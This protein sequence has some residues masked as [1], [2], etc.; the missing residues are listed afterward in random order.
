MPSSVLVRSTASAVAFVATL[1]L[2]S[3]QVNVALC[4]AAG[5]AT[6]CQWLTTQAALQATGLFN[7]VDIIDVTTAG[8]GTPTLAQLSQYD[9]LLC[10]T[11]TTPANNVTWGDVLADY[12]DQGGGV[13]VAVFANSSTTTGRNIGGRW[14]TGYEVV[15]DQGGSATG[16]ASL[17]IVHDPLHPVMAGVGAFTGGTISSRPTATAL[18]IG[19]TLIAEWSDGKVLVAQG[20]LSNRV[21][22]GFY[23]PPA[24]CSQSGWAQGGDQLMA[25]AL[26]H[27]ANTA[28]YHTYGDGC[29]GTAGVPVLAPV[30][31]SRPVLGASV[32]VTVTNAPFDAGIMLLGFSDTLSGGIPL[33]FDL[34]FLGMTGCSLLTDAFQTDFLIGAGGVLGYSLAIPNAPVFLGAEFYNQAGIFDPTANPFGFTASNGGRGRIGLP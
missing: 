25:N 5:S 24:S 34:T 23:P 26:L 20:A 11:N 15:L 13:V 4:G 21:D 16:A 6:G 10:W 18:E 30:V 12:V 8:G 17:G 22:L 31:G 3:A 32:Q 2:A 7:T 27:V 9:A 33:P 14:Q 28:K 29:V 1:G 19:S